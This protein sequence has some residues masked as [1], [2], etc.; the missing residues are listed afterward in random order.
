MD[1]EE[2]SNT[3]SPAVVIVIMVMASGSWT[4]AISTHL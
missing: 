3:E 1:G 2:T 4:Q